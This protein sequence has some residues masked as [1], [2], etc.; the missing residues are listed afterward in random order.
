MAHQS[1][2]DGLGARGFMLKG[3]ESLIAR[4]FSRSRFAAPSTAPGYG[5]KP[6]PA[7]AKCSMKLCGMAKRSLAMCISQERRS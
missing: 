4:A 5:Q 1:L 3:F 7:C 6:C 2:I